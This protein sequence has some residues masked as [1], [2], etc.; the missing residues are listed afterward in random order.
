[1]NFALTIKTCCGLYERKPIKPRTRRDTGSFFLVK[2]SLFSKPVL[3]KTRT[4]R[5]SIRWKSDLSTKI[6]RDFIQAVYTIVLHPYNSVDSLDEIPFYFRREIRFPYNA[7]RYFEQIL[8]TSPN[9]IAA[10]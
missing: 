5:L 9:K 8:G 6:K 4:D 2:Y 10:M 3:V 1:M 7:M